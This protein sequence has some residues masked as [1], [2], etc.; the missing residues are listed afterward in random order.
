MA[1]TVYNNVKLGIASISSGVTNSLGTGFFINKDNEIYICT[2]AH[3]I[4]DI[5]S[6]YESVYPELYA[7][8]GLDNRVVDLYVVGIDKKAD[9]AVCQVKDD[10]SDIV[11]LK[12]S[13]DNV[14]VGDVCYLI[15]NPLGVDEMSFSQGIIRD[16]SISK[17]KYAVESVMTTCPA[18]QGLSGCSI[19]NKVGD[20]IGILS[21]GVA[22]QET[23]SWGRNLNI[24]VPIIETIISTKK[25]HRFRYLGGILLEVNLPLAIQLNRKNLDGYAIQKA[26]SDSML[27]R[28]D[29][30]LEINGK[31]LKSAAVLTDE[32]ALSTTSKAQLKVDRDGNIQ[33]IE[34]PIYTYNDMPRPARQSLPITYP[35]DNIAMPYPIGDQPP[36]GGYLPIGSHSPIGNN[37]PIIIKDR[38]QIEAI[39]SAIASNSGGSNLPIK[40]IKRQGSNRIM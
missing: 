27:M 20:V 31:P 13:E 4:A 37:S 5:D 28:K 14:S 17:G 6:P 7:S 23:L 21:A 29:V 32:I 11:P 40:I 15:G 16:M 35:R 33:Y 8:Y 36:I 2:A 18:H 30:I 9:I 1:S 39:I 34:V 12:W 10:L 25:D 26:L 19:L 24:A 3:V 22:E 38:E